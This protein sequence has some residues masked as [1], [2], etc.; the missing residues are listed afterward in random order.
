MPVSPKGAVPR[1]ARLRPV[2]GLDGIRLHLADEVYAL[3]R[4]TAIETRDPDPAI[5]YWAFA[6]AGGLALSR[7]L[8][9]HPDTV[10]GR[11]V[12]DLASGSGLCAIVAMRAGAAA[13]TA[14]DI[15]PYAVE[16]IAINARA[17]GC[18]VSVVGRDVLDDAPPDADVVLAGDCWYDEGLAARVLP[19]L[20]RCRDRGID[21]LV[22]DNGRRH[23]PVD[24][25]VEIASY[26]VRTTTDLEDLEPRPGR[27]FRLRPAGSPGT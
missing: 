11:R 5:P 7:Y 25:L 22:G 20:Q 3:W 15:D 17:N 18:R 2:A 16:A 9:D 1:H 8:Q 13:A 4:A 23:L 12:F 27:V 24:A 14:A 6:W 26:D 21:V 19:W 10:R